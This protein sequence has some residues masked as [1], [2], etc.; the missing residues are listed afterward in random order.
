MAAGNFTTLPQHFK[1]NGYFTA[2]IGKVFHPGKQVMQERQK[3]CYVLKNALI[4]IYIYIY[5]YMINS[6]SNDLKFLQHVSKTV[7]NSLMFFF[8]YKNA[9]HR[10]GQGV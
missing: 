5:I 3:N 7:Q 10:K 6:L 9:I 1:D 8:R 4:Y 2:S